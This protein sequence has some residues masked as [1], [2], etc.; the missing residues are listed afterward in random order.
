MCTRFALS[1]ENFERERNEAAQGE[2][3]FKSQEAAPA[4]AKQQGKP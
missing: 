1:K 2:E 4:L 3:G